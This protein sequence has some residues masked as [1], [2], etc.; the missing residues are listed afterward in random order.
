M[1]IIAAIALG[2]GVYTYLD[3]DQDGLL[4][5]PYQESVSLHI[6]PEQPNV[7]WVFIN[8]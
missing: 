3:Q 7:Q 1:E 2:Y 8:G 6:E 4:D 5:T